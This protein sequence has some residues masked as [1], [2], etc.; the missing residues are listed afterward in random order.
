MVGVLLN[1]PNKADD[2]EQ[3]VETSNSDVVVTVLVSFLSDTLIDDIIN[4]VFSQLKV[5]WMI[6]HCPQ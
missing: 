4:H 1:N 5:N 2:K 6:M 3:L